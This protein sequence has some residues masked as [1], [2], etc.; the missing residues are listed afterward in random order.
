MHLELTKLF[1]LMCMFLYVLLLEIYEIIYKLTQ[2]VFDFDNILGEKF[3]WY[4]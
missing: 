4:N 1:L 3:T 2:Y